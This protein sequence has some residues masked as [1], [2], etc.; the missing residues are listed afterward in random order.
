MTKT[1]ADRLVRSVYREAMAACAKAGMKVD[2]Y[3]CWL[4]EYMDY[5]FLMPHCGDFICALALHET[6]LLNIA[7]LRREVGSALKLARDRMRD[8]GLLEA[9]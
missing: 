2:L 7:S 3:A 8:A 1:A 4:A 9:H 5:V 6:Q